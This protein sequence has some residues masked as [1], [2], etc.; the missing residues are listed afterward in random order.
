[1]VCSVGCEDGGVL[2]AA[3]GRGQVETIKDS[4][5]IVPSWVQPDKVSP[6]LALGG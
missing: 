4:L 1:M 5:L 6:L 2:S 3:L